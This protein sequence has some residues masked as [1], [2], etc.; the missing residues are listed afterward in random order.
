MLPFC[1]RRLGVRHFELMSVEGLGVSW[2]LRFLSGRLQA[3]GRWVSVYRE[4]VILTNVPSLGSREQLH[5]CVAL[6]LC[7]PPP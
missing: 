1:V 6:P 5:A 7:P 2:F 3:S 4:G